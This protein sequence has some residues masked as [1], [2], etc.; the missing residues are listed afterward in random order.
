MRYGRFL[1]PIANRVLPRLNLRDQ[2]PAMA[3][4]RTVAAKFTTAA[5]VC[6]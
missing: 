6:K 4:L 3:T 5:T 2:P 1:E